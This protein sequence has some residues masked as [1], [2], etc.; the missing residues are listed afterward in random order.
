MLLRAECFLYI[1]EGYYYYRYRDD[2][3]VHSRFHDRQAEVIT[4]CERSAALF[5]DYPEALRNEFNVAIAIRCKMLVEKA[6]RTE[7]YNRSLV[8]ELIRKARIRFWDVWRSP[9]VKRPVKR[10]FFLYVCFPRL[11]C[12]L[13]NRK[14]LS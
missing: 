10:N 8:C 6:L 7:S 3:L 12:F 2:S 5:A 9:F 11:F 4:A 1:N 13:K 14:E